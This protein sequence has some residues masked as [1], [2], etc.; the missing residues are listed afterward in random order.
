MCKS[1]YPLGLLVLVSALFGAGAALAQAPALGVAK[2]EKPA[3][4]ESTAA[5]SGEAGM[6]LPTLIAP[7]TDSQTGYI[8]AIGGYDSS[9][10]SAQMEALAD[11]TIIGPLALRAGV[12]YSQ[13]PNSFRP[14][15]GLRVQVL[16]QEDAGFDLGAGVFYRPEGFTEAEGEVEVAVAFGRRFGRIGTFANLVY[17]QDPEGAERD[18]ELRLGA[19]YSVTSLFQAGLDARLRFDLGSEEGERRTE[20]EAEY[21]IA[22]GPTASYA[23][24]PVAAIAQVGMSIF[25]REPARPGALALF[26]LA[27]VL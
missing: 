10:R 21:D 19:L 24:G 7:R 26:G 15:V 3:A 2:D 16:K 14:S 20:G 17:G 8:R 13:K 25:G 23:L 5:V 6:F 27:G 18:G 4:P 11:V 9:H 22:F 12:L 1:N